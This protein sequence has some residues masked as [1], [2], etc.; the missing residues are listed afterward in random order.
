M[1]VKN[2]D[3]VSFCG[4][5][6]G[7]CIKGKGESKKKSEQI[8]EDMQE[9]GLDHWQQHEPKQESFNYDD[10]KKGLK[11]LTSFDCN[12]CHAGGGNPECIIR[13]CAEEKRLNNCGKCPEM[14]C[15]IA[16]KAKEEQGIDIEKNFRNH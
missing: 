2:R 15:D 4:I 12:G 16:K 5:L 11:W 6:C 1:P 8:L 9:S 10:L 13:K 7:K 3:E 14:P